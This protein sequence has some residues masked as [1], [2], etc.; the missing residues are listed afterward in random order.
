MLCKPAE[1]LTS[2]QQGCGA[3]EDN[4]VNSRT[5]LGRVPAQVP[6]FGEGIPPISEALLRISV[7]F[8]ITQSRKDA[9]M[10]VTPRARFGLEYSVVVLHIPG[11]R[12]VSV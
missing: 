3:I 2:I 11:K 5:K 7:K 4:N 1:L 12:E 10:C 8:V 9:E 6:Q